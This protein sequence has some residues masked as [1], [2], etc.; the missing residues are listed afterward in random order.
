MIDRLYII[1]LWAHSIQSKRAT[2]VH[3][4][5]L[6]RLRVMRISHVVQQTR[7]G[8]FWLK[9]SQIS[10]VIWWLISPPPPPPSEPFTLTTGR[11]E[12][13]NLQPPRPK[14]SNWCEPLT[15]EIP[16]KPQRQLCA[17]WQTDP[18]RV[19][20]RWVNGWPRSMPPAFP[21]ES[22]VILLITNSKGR[23]LRLRWSR[24]QSIRYDW[25]TE[26]CTDAYNLFKVM[27]FC[28]LKCLYAYVCIH[29][30]MLVSK[31]VCMYRYIGTHVC[32][33]YA[34]I[35]TNIIYIRKFRHCS[36]RMWPSQPWIKAEGD[37][38]FL[39]RL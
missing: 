25:G 35:H 10:P 37:T 38:T 26:E 11:P 36:F 24:R 32:M 15:D 7:D 27:S 23:T 21:R 12:N 4:M 2:Y 6:S 18:A 29:A 17:T 9:T 1:F 3:D 16:A 34:C 13:L 5:D 28:S 19:R 39:Q 8:V 22:V 30:C 20:L 14:A 33:H 31:Y